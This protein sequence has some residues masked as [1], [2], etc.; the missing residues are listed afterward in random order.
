MDQ[1]ARL[2]PLVADHLGLR[3]ERAEPTE[4][5]PTQYHAH[6]GATCKFC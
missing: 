3:V 6:D 5:A 4:A 2:V 1:L